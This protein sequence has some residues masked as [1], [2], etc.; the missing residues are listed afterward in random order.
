MISISLLALNA[1][2]LGAGEI[3]LVRTFETWNGGIIM[4]TDPAGITYH[5]PSGHLYISDSEIDEIDSIWNNENIFE[6]SLAGNHVFNT[7]DAHTSNGKRE[8]TGITYN[9]FD[10]FFYVTDDVR[11]M[12]MRYDATFGSPLASV[13]LTNDDSTAKD[14]EGIT[15]DPST[16]YLYV[17]DGKNAGGRQVLV[18]NSNLGFVSKFS[19]AAR[20]SDPEGIAYSSVSNTLFI[21]SSPEKKIFEYTLAGNFVD[22]YDIS[23]FSP[24]PISPEGLTFAPSSDPH[25]DPNNYNLYIVDAQVDNNADPN[26]RDGIVYEADI[27]IVP[28]PIQLGSFT[29]SMVNATTVQLAWMTVSEVNNYGFEVQKTPAALNNYQNVPNSFIPGHGTTNVPQYYSYTDAT[30]SSGI[31]Y[32]RLKQIDLDGTVH[33]TDAIQ[34]DILTSVKEAELPNE[35]ALDQNYPNPFNP[36][37]VIE[38]VLPKESQV[39]LDVYNVLGQHVITLVDGVREAG[40]HSVQFDAADLVSGFYF[41]RIQARLSSSSVGEGASNASSSGQSFIQ[42]KKLLLLK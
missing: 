40:Y 19:V 7:Y 2:W 17:A 28:L 27:T 13:V 31:W 16:G 41:Y 38:Y 20:V 21:V 36:S 11:N 35:F 9:P 14:P 37:T 1:S 24:A 23:G 6:V 33:Y 3:N 12:I 4:S 18:Y 32:Y 22:E 26:E 30:A 39:K 34:V 42:T 29:G 8:P 10:R 15:C 5:P 25:D